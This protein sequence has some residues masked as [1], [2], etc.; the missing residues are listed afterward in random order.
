M[1]FSKEV[2]KVGV[3]N[4]PPFFIEKDQSGLFLEI[5]QALFKELP[6]YD[7]EFVFMSNKRLQHEINTGKRIDVA[8]NIFNRSNVNAYLSTPIFRYSDVVISK[9]SSNLK[10]NSV[11]D[12]KGKS[13]AAYQ[14][15]KDLLGEEFQ[16]IA[17]ENSTYTEYPHPSETTYL[18]ISGNKEV[19]VGDINIFWYDLERKHLSS[20][21]QLTMQD[22]TIH[23]LWPD[24]YSHIAFKN[25][26]IRDMINQAIVKLN[27][28]GV[29][30]SIY[31]KYNLSKKS[32]S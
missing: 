24:V 12:L 21:S 29:I 10:I 18:L 26:K 4:F 20:T 15:A 30:K 25:E 32:A 1:V 19:R 22:F 9:K 7:I 27:N 2:L 28:N 3:G 6:N 16:R 11:A 13:I 8:C 17:N 5:T 31:S 23:K 14:G